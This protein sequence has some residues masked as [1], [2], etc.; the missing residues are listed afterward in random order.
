MGVTPLIF[1]T[2]IET[3]IAY[4][5]SD[6]LNPSNVAVMSHLQPARCSPLHLMTST[7]HDLHLDEIGLV[8]RLNDKSQ[9]F[10]RGEGHGGGANQIGWRFAT[11]LFDGEQHLKCILC[12][13]WVQDSGSKD[14]KR[15]A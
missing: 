1:R 2:A 7:L 5:T 12:N 13:K 14:H 6:K 9:S 8:E 15:K 3:Y 10:S 11:I 4:F